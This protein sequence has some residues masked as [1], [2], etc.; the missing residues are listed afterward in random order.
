MRRFNRISGI[1][2]KCALKKRDTVNYIHIPSK[3]LQICSKKVTILN[4]NTL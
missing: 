3:L 4:Y 1:Y 2:R